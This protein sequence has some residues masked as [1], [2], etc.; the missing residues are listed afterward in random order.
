MEKKFLTII[1]PV[2]NTEIKLL[3]KCLQSVSRLNPKDVQII[4]I[5]DF[6]NTK[7]NLFLKKIKRKNLKVYRNSKNKGISF[8]RNFG[9]KLSNSKYITFVDADDYIFMDEF[10]SIKN[11]IIKEEPDLAVTKFDTNYFQITENRNFKDKNFQFKGEKRIIYDFS[12]EVFKPYWHFEAVWCLFFKRDFLLKNRLKFENKAFRNEDQEYVVKSFFLSGKTLILNK[13]FYFYRLH[14]SN[15]RYT[16]QISQKNM[17]NGNIRLIKNLFIF[18]KKKKYL[19]SVNNFPLSTIKDLILSSIPFAYKIKREKLVEM[20][21]LIRQIQKK[22]KKNRIQMPKLN[23]LKINNTFDLFFRNGINLK[24]IKSIYIYCAF[25]SSIP[26]IHFFNKKRVK[27]NG[28]ID[29][30]EQLKGRFFFNIKVYSL[31]EMIKLKKK[32]NVLI[33]ITHPEKNTFLKIKKNVLKAGFLSSNI[34]NIGYK[35]IFNFYN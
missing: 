14:N 27:I 29:T 25:E 7:I 13:R 35:K 19:Y 28:I 32:N 12:K 16:N 31:K 3:K 9:I 20:N 1:I 22:F 23:F 10:R 5:D 34:I 33:L 17:F 21:V 30:N 15:I 2:F 26:I 4:I 8:S 11:A 24:K 6:S 18:F